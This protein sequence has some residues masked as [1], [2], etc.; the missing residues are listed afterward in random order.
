MR[1]PQ[2]ISKIERGLIAVAERI[3]SAV[4]GWLFDRWLGVET[5]KCVDRFDLD[6]DASL[7]AYAWSYEPCGYPRFRRIMKMVPAAPEGLTFVDIG[8]GKGRQ[9]I[10]AALHGFPRVIG[11]EVSPALHVAAQRNVAAFRIRKSTGA[12]IILENVEATRY[13]LPRETCLLFMFN[14]FQEPIVRR[15]LASIKGQVRGRTEPLYV[16][17]VHPTVREAF[18]ESNLFEEIAARRW[19]TDTVIYQLRLPR[20]RNR[21]IMVP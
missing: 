13:V 19:P 17:Y 9:L 18:D 10:A 21:D 6:V 3:E 12:Q 15:F 5:R 1:L 8:S 14:P 7:R 11:V 2:A 4:T 20:R 16:A